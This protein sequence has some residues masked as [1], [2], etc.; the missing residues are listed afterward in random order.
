[1]KV[2]PTI[3]SFI[4]F[5][6]EDGVVNTFFGKKKKFFTSTRFFSYYIPYFKVFPYTIGKFNSRQKKRTLAELNSVK[7]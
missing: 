4:V 5:T 7:T 3:K 2:F 1:M 6:L